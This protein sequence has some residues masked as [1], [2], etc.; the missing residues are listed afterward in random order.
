MARRVFVINPGSTSTKLALYRDTT[1]VFQRE[2][3]H[4]R[5]DLAG[6]GSVAGQREFRMVRIRRVLAE[7]GVNPADMDA[8]AGRGG[9]LRPLVGGVYEVSDEMINDMLAARYGEHACNLGAVL[10]DEL[11]REWNV[12]AFIVDPVVTD[13][14]ED[15]ARLTGLPLVRRRSLFHALNQRGAARTVARRLGRTYGNADFLVIHMGGGVSIGAHRRGR[16]VDVVN[17]LD[18]EGPFTPERTG[19]LP[20][21]SVLD[22]LERGEYTVES[23]RRT[24]LRGGGMVA[25]MGTNDFREFEAMLDRGE[26][27]AALFFEAMAYFIARYAASL[28]PALVDRDGRI[29]VAAVILTGGLARS[30]RMVRELT[31]LLRHLGPVEVVTGD[32]EMASLAAGAIRAITGR[33][34]ARQYPSSQN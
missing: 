25:H 34:R 3:A 6:F 28:A 8:V 24:V 26:S 18:G 10:A 7:E 17:A 16:V 21:L 1:L 29:D 15:R 23:L 9:L 12:P 33:E 4:S 20:L 13:E 5:E 32:E 19:G 27:G 14:I 11:A 31:R 30:K 22:L 2:L